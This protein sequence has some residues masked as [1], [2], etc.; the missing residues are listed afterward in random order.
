MESY[1]DLLVFTECFYVVNNY[2]H[3][4]NQSCVPY[5]YASQLHMHL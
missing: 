3:M 5:C 2:A 1:K 4:W